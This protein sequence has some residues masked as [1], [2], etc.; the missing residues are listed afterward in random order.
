[1]ATEIWMASAEIAPLAHTGGLGDVLRALPK[2]L[3]GRGHSVRRFMPGY[4][5][6]PRDRFEDEGVSLKIPLGNERVPVRFLTRT[7]KSGERTTLVICDEFFDRD[8]IYGPLGGEFPDNAKRYS[9]FCRAICEYAQH[10]E[11]PPQVIH[12]HDWPAALIPLFVR[13]AYQWSA[14]PL[15]VFSIHNLAYQGRFGS[16]DLQ[17][18]SLSPEKEQELFTPEGIEFYGDLNFMKAGILYSDHITTVSPSTAENICTPEFGFGLEG[19][20]NSQKHK[21]IGIL[22]GADYEE[23]NPQ[24]DPYLP[25]NFTKNTYLQ[26]RKSARKHLREAFGMP[27]AQRPI[28]GIVGRLAHQK[29]MDVFIESALP[30]VTMGVDFCIIGDGDSELASRLKSLQEHLPNRVGV[31]IG[32]NEALSHLLMAGSDLVLLPSRFEPCGLVQM[33]AMKYGAIPIVHQTGGLKDTVIDVLNNP[34]EGTGFH[35]APLD[36]EQIRDAVQ[37]A[38]HYMKDSPKQWQAMQKR[39][40]NTNFSWDRAAQSYEKLYGLEVTHSPK[41]KSEVTVPAVAR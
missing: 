36:P 3:A 32:F 29:G 6:I 16:F 33:H 28:L 9:L 35:F 37:T 8:G 1:M 17:W 11:R 20:L 40:M 25:K 2:A 31:Y 14:Q 18:L 27:A 19:L 23:W 5:M 13:H 7:E 15:T 41:G 30:L 38:L 39:A 34:E 21:L 4:Q 22:N 10:T 12:S 24:T 26:A